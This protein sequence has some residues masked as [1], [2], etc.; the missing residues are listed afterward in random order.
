MY[1]QVYGVDSRVRFTGKVLYED[2]ILDKKKVVERACIKNNL[3]LEGSVGVG[4][5]ES[6]I[7]F[8]KM[9]ERP[10]AFNPSMKLYL[11]A[12]KNAWEVVVERKDVIYKL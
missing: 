11:A 12:K 3:T 7:P 2:I 4:D 5:T 6:D 8:L 1:A 10:I 9:M